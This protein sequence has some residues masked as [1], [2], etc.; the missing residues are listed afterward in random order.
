MMDD[1]TDG[2]QDY[3]ADFGCSSA[4]ADSEVF[5]PAEVDMTAAIT[6]TPITGTTVGMT[7][8]FPS[9]SCQS[10]STG[11]DAVYGLQLPVPVTTLVLDLSTSAYDTVLS[12]R[13]TQCMVQLG[14]DDDSGD[15]G[16]QSKLTMANVAAGNYAVV[17]DGYSSGAGAFT[18]AVKGTVAAGTS[19]TS[20]LFAAGV[21]ACP[22]GTTCTGTPATCQ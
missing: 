20:P 10:T 9:H 5:C 21:L 17:I 8:N 2:L 12:L 19:C 11:P 7:N 6:S 22:M 13:D 14:C 4:A 15:P 18:L 16:N 3:P 1:D